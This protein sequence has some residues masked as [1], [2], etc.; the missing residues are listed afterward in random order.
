M[1]N[2]SP[3]HSAGTGSV[4]RAYL[5]GESG[6]IARS[7]AVTAEN[8]TDAIRQAEA[9]NHRGA[10]ELWDRSRVVFRHGKGALALPVSNAELRAG[11]HW[12]RDT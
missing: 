12:P 8:D 10:V 3:D 1:T 4:Y 5:I 11:L 2:P 6:R 7:V 9:I